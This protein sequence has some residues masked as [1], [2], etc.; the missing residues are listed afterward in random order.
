TRAEKTERRQ[1]RLMILAGGIAALLLTAGPLAAATPATEQAFIAAFTK[2]FQAKDAAAIKALVHTDG[3]HP[4]ILDLYMA[5]L[6][7]GAGTGDL[8]VELQALTPDDVK[9][10]AQ[11][12]SGPGGVNVKLAP[13]PYKK[14]VISVSTKNSN[15]SSTSTTTFYVADEGD[16]IRISAP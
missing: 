4:T 9:E 12:M 5:G 3:P 7:S 2:A 10:A 6:T 1:M 15:G 8:K 16:K 13:Q 11:V 14:L